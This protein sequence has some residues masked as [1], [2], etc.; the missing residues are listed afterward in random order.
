[1]NGYPNGQTLDYST[2]TLNSNKVNISTTPHY[3]DSNTY[4]EFTFS[5]PV[6]VQPGVLYAFVINSNSADYTLFYGQQNQTAIPS[7]AIATPVSQGGV[8]PANPTKIGAAPYVGALFESQNAITWTADQTKDLMFVINQAVFNTSLQPTISFVV[9]KNLPFRKLGR[10]DIQYNLNAN[11]I[12]NLIGCQ[13][14]PSRPMHSFGLT[15]TDFVPSVTNISYQYNTTLLNSLAATGNFPVTPGKFGAPPQDNVYLNDG[16][17]ERVLLNSSNNSFTLYAT[18]AS[19]DTNVSPVISDDGLSLYSCIYFINNM[20]LDSS[21]ISLAN[22]GSGYS[23]NTTV[24]V[25]NPDIGTD[26]AVVSFTL[27]TS[28][29]SATTN[30]ISSIYV[31]YPG[32]GY[33]TTPT[34]TISDP[35][36]RSGNSNASIIVTGET[37]TTGGNGYARY[38]T[39]PVVLTN[40]SGDL[41][42]YYTAYKPVNSA[43]YIYYRILNGNDTT[44][45]ASQKWQLM[46]QVGVST[47][48]TDRT[49]LIEYTAAPGINGIANNN[50]SYASVNGQTYTS[51]TQFQIKV[52]MATSDRTSVPF[53]TNIRA[54]ALP[55]GTGI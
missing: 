33:I 8:L 24:T 16:Q 17:G 10:N 20:G 26:K 21:C 46:T 38:V 45:L 23:S 47:F 15:T 35:T 19:T 22:T 55:S 14:S 28:P 36:T 42:V 49:N 9:P 43:V 2:V 4:T 7:T 27:N 1:L 50:L 48:S 13:F 30:G 11:T 3:L 18:L 32:S 34:I 51:F 37:S 52:V 31:S 44:P 12:N 40:S 54:L 6:Y 29:F 5:A 41:R 25:S 53:L 39:K